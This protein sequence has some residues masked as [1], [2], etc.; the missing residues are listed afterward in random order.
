[1]KTQLRS[2]RLTFTLIA[3]SDLE[4]IHELH[5]L[6]ETDEFNTLGIPESIEQTKAILESWI[7]DS[8]HELTPA[9]TFSIRS[10][11]TDAFIG[12]V[13]LKCGKPKFCI[14]EIWYKLHLQHWRK[15][16]ATEAVNK[17]LSFGFQEMGLHRIEAGCAVANT[18]SA[19]VLEKVGMLKEGR[20]R[21]V[22]PLK[23][24]WSDNY[25]YAILEEDWFGK[26]ST[27]TT[28]I[29]Q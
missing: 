21:K 5:S 20:K 7:A 23:S 29:S 26:G 19:M 11:E 2:E 8:R 17:I 27:R 12:L 28:T 1:M 13:A 18:A 15:G 25:E 24:G 3:P 6:P 14:G 10:R 22:L 9:Y 16:F 4:D